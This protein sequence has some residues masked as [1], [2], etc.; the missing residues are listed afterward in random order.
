[1]YILYLLRSKATGAPAVFW[2][3]ASRSHDKLLIERVNAYLPDARA[4]VEGG[5]ALD[6]QILKPVDAIKL[7]MARA[8]EG[9]D[10]ISVTGILLF[11]Q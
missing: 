9:K 10:T 11:F 8:R 5:D 7:S 2:L 1:M 6:L 4:N 3:D